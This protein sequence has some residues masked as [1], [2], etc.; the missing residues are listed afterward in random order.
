MIFKIRIMWSGVKTKIYNAPE[1]NI[2]QNKAQP[3]RTVRTSGRKR[4]PV[5]QFLY[6]YCH[7][8][9]IHDL[10]D[11]FL[12][13]KNEICKQ[14]FCMKCLGI[15]RKS[16]MDEM[17]KNGGWTCLVCKG[18]C[19]C[20]D[21]KNHDYIELLGIDPDNQNLLLDNYGLDRDRKSVVVDGYEIIEIPMK[22]KR[23]KRRR[24]KIRKWKRNSKT[25]GLKRSK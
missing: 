20:P 11:N 15:R 6:F 24:R 17:K 23:E 13:C 8:C 14:G 22:H 7:G 19:T 4:M 5:K 1:N 3:E 2:Y 16:Q 18:I 12:I 25:D 21:C 10:M 9:G